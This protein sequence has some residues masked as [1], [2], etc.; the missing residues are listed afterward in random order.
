MVETV[1]ALTVRARTWQDTTELVDKL[2][3]VLRGWANY[4]SVGLA[5]EQRL[6]QPANVLAHPRGGDRL[7]QEGGALANAILV[8][9]RW[10]STVGWPPLFFAALIMD[11]LLQ[12][13]E[14]SS[15]IS[16]TPAA[17]RT[18]SQNSDHVTLRRG[19]RPVRMTAWFARSRC[20]ARGVIGSAPG[21]AIRLPSGGERC[22]RPRG[23]VT[24]KALHLRTPRVRPPQNR[25]AQW[26]SR[27]FCSEE[28]A[29]SDQA[30][31]SHAAGNHVAVPKV[32][33]VSERRGPNERPDNG[34]RVM[35]ACHCGQICA[36]KMVG[37]DCRPQRNRRAVTDTVGERKEGHCDEAHLDCPNQK[38]HAQ[39][40]VEHA[41]GT[42]AS[43]PVRS[44]TED[45]PA[46]ERAEP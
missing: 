39:R 10:Q 13:R 30:G 41:Q 3:R 27:G 11:P 34:A 15:R 37:N 21:K 46:G 31:R 32:D 9:H 36:R 42:L 22:Q 44:M 16:W 38:Q 45:E 40:N 19:V 7:D 17:A 26:N 29:G 25:P 23:R 8:L 12:P 14:S 2:N 43:K 4:F 6:T 20:T 28:I 5:P 35:Q 18:R 33:R 24:G 1:H